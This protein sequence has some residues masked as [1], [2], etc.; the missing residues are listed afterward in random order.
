MMPCSMPTASCSTLA[1][2]ARQLVVQDA[3][4]TTRC[5]LRQLVVV[6]AVDDGQV[7]TVGRR[8]NDDALGAGGEMRRGLVLGG[9]DAGA[10]E[11]DIDVE[12]LPRQLGRVLDRRAP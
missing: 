1:T 3:L 9:E 12:L 5:V 7:G 10:F 6:D 11:R 8:R 4:E 2:G